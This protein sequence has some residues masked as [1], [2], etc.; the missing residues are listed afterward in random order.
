MDIEPEALSL[1][2]DNFYFKEQ[3]KSKEQDAELK[4]PLSIKK[5][6]LV[7]EKLPD[8]E[9]KNLLNKILTAAKI[10][11][12]ETE[13]V[14]M[15]DFDGSK[16]DFGGVSII[17]ND[18][19]NENEKYKIVKSENGTMLKSDSLSKISTNQQLKAKLWNCLKS[20]FLE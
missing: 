12:D 6:L 3:V 9:E 7:F 19:E 8:E 1:L 17:W 5:V 20:I 11:E 10:S 16:K 15:K 18:G 4:P 13:F 2:F 14:K